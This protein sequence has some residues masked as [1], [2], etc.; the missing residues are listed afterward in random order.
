M[1]SENTTEPNPIILNANR[2]LI[3]VLVVLILIFAK[4][5]LLPLAF[6]IL[7]ALALLGPVRFFEK[8]GMSRSWA[9]VLC[10]LVA[11]VLISGVFTFISAQVLSFQKDFP[12]L[13]TKFLQL[14]ED[15]KSFALN[16]LHLNESVIHENFAPML[17]KLLAAAP[18]V[19]GNLVSFFSSSIFIAAFTC[20]Y[21]LMILV[22]R[23]N[24]AYFF[25]KTFKEV[26]G[27]SKYKIAN[28]TQSVI[29]SYIV[30]LALEVLFVA[31]LLGIA[32]SIVGVKYAILLAV[33]SAI[34]NLVPYLGFIIAGVLS[35]LVSFATNSPEAAI[36]VGII[37]VIVHLVDSN[38][39]LPAV[40]G[41][42]VSINAL[43]TV[44]GVF[45]GNLIWGI[46]GMFLAVP[47]VAVIK[48]ICDEIPSM[49]HWGVLLGGRDKKPKKLILKIRKRIQTSVEIP[50]DENLSL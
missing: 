20:I 1:H 31:V 50:K 49:Y 13:E 16:D 42:K 2:L 29:R 27:I 10:L 45:L 47:T 46:P 6:A 3:F 40:V 37:A 48:V 41:N 33:I 39:F 19:I 23:D 21:T 14:V 44:I 25:S 18:A 26:G 7:F 11:L 32:Y 5:V 8:K 24:I 9:A 22:Y 36:W 38:L 35:M 28:N 4:S 17:D 12:L 43:V 30:G 15:L 34:F